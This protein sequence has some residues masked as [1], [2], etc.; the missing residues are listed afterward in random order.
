MP[1][2]IN[3][4]DLATFTR[5]HY[6]HI[7]VMLASGYP[8]PALKLDRG[9]LGEFAFVAKPYRLSDLARSLRSVH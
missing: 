4:I 7:K 6:P 3:G 5:E 1:D 9:K 8:Q 2:G